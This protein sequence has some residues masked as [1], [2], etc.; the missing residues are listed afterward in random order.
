MLLYDR[1]NPYDHILQSKVKEYRAQYY[2][3]AFL[4]INI[5]RT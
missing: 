3:N 2:F 5:L 4:E 1:K